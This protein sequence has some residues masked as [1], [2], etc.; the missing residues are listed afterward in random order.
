MYEGVRGALTAD[1][2]LEADNR[3][4]PFRVRDIDGTPPILKPK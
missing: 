2:A 1:D 4:P 3:E